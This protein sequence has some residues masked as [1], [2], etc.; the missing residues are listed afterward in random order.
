MVDLNPLFE[1]SRA[2]CVAICAFLVPANLLATIQAMVFVG[3]NRPSSQVGL[4]TA[5]AALYALTMILHVGTWFMIGV[6]M[7]PTFILLWLGF[8]CL[9]VNVWAIAHPSSM[10]SLLRHLWA[11]ASNFEFKQWAT[12]SKQ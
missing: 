11:I 1:F 4:I 7:L 12:G 5:F 9:A 6:V 3:L 10:A 8:T 2:N